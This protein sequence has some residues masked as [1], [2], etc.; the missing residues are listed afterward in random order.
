MRLK[1]KEYEQRLQGYSYSTLVLMSEIMGMPR[2][3]YDKGRLITSDSELT[4]EQVVEKLKA[5]KEEYQNQT[6]DTGLPVDTELEKEIE[7]LKK[8]EDNPLPEGAF[9]KT[10]LG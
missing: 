5:L 4:E 3:V 6:S 2:E 7:E 10:S 8:T 9:G 1:G